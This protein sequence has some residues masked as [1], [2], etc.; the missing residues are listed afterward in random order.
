MASITCGNCHNTHQ[1]VLEVRICYGSIAPAPAEAVDGD[2]YLASLAAD[3]PVQPTAP[4]PVVEGMYKD[5]ETGRIYKVQ[6]SRSSGY[7]YAKELIGGSFDY[8]AGAMKII[9]SEWRMTLE[10]AKEYGALYGTC[11]VCGRTLTNEVSIEAGIGPIC[12]G[13]L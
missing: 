12:A 8:A 1:S 5:P 6:K 10:Q 4:E 7:N 2:A 13:R 11:C 3:A 9:R